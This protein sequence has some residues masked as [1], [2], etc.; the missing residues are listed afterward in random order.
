MYSC[1]RQVV[2][3]KRYICSLGCPIDSTVNILFQWSFGQT[4]YWC[5]WYRCLQDSSSRGPSKLNQLKHRDRGTLFHLP[6]PSS[7]SSWF[8]NNLLNHALGTRYWRCFYFLFA[9]R[10]AYFGM[11]LLSTTSTKTRL[12]QAMPPCISL[13][14]TISSFIRYAVPAFLV[15]NR[16]VFTFKHRAGRREALEIGFT[17]VIF[18]HGK[19]LLF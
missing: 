8:I 16:F 14:A 4:G 3:Q 11:S 2:D 9:C 1:E 7:C 15:S 12:N 19:L 5:N 6:P 17:V 10:W 18:P 13:G